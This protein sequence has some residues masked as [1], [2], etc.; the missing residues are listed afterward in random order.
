MDDQELD[1]LLSRVGRP[2]SDGSLAAAT[3]LIEATREE[4]RAGR[5]RKRWAR[6]GLLW[7]GA[8]TAAA[9]L[10]AGAGITAAQL[11]IP[12]FQSIEDGIQRIPVAVPVDYRETSGT[13]VHCLAFMEF[14]HLDNASEAELQ[15]FVSRHDWSGFGQ[16]VRDAGA[17][18]RPTD[19]IDAL[20]AALY[21]EAE[22][23]LPGLRHGP[24]DT[25]ATSFTGFGMSCTPQ[26][27]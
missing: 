2:Q 22:G 18:E 1:R 7:G 4:Y 3:E 19:F 10:T 6:K 26:S 13:P 25:D 27:E 21:R 24:I 23:V 8:L 9:L 5:Q 17:T 20:D 15:S 16:R 14:R 11:G 12:P